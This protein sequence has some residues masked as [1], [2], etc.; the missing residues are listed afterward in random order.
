[1]SRAQP[2]TTVRQPVNHDVAPGRN[3][4]LRCLSLIFL[5]RIRNMDG[6]VVTAL[7]IPPVENVAAFGSL[8]ISLLLLRSSRRSSERNLVATDYLSMCHQSQNSLALRNDDLVGLLRSQPR[9][10]ILCSQ[11]PNQQHRDHRASMY[12]LH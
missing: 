4:T 10:E 2:S 5:V 7:R 12:V 8:V 3:S 9:C 1:M 11:H 6:L